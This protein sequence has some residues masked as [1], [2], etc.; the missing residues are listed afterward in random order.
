M[1]SALLSHVGHSAL[2]VIAGSSGSS[3]LAVQLFV[4]RTLII[5]SE[6]GPFLYTELRFFCLFL[7][8]V[9]LQHLIVN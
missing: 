7:G 1:H 5:H 3:T 4:Q 9:D 6:A 2:R 8:Y